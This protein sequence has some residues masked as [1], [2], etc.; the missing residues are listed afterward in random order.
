MVGAIDNVPWMAFCELAR[1]FHQ[2]SA[3]SSHLPESAKDCLSRVLVV[4]LLRL[5]TRSGAILC[6]FKHLTRLATKPGEIFG[7]EA[8][9][10]CMESL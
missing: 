3:T 7:L 6:I 10:S 1:I 2:V 8:M 9:Q 4:V 5:R